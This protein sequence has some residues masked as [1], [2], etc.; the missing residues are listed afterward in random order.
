MDINDLRALSTLL[1]FATFIA[2]CW[3]VFR[4]NRKS[5][6]EE[7]SMLPFAEDSVANEDSKNR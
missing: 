6:Y 2:V 3:L 7:A 4:K 5:Y 1:I